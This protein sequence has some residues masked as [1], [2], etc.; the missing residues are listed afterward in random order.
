M[1]NLANLFAY[2]TLMLPEMM[3]QL[4]GKEIQSIPGTL[5]GY[6]CY[7]V[8]HQIYPAIVALDGSNVTGIVYQ[9]LRNGDLTKLDEYEGEMYERKTVQ[10]RLND[11]TNL[12]C[13]TYVCKE[14]YI[15]YLDNKLWNPSRIS[16]EGLS[17]LLR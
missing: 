1:P 13:Q 12:P 14:E 15:S 6:A 9:N 17:G 4:L 3:H 11:G 7:E 16:P 2:G 8:K 5:N 10:V